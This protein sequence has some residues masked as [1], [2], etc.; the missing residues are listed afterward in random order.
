MYGLL[1]CCSI[2]EDAAFISCYGL[3]EI[4]I[5]VIASIVIFPCYVTIAVSAIC[6]GLVHM[7]SLLI[8]PSKGHQI[9]FASFLNW[10][11]CLA[12]FRYF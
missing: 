6:G 9:L 12:V 10:E 5:K 7:H 4:G 8:S 11:C 2:S 3:P 1:S